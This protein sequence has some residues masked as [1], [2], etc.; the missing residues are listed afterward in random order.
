M[1]LGCCHKTLGFLLNNLS[2]FVTRSHHLD[3]NRRVLFGNGRNAFR[4]TQDDGGNDFVIVRYGDPLQR[5]M[6]ANHDFCLI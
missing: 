5:L 2:S 3:D 1:V 4:V 6:I